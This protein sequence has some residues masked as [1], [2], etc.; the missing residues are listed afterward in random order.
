MSSE[1]VR[2]GLQRF[3]EMTDAKKRCP[4]PPHSREITM[5]FPLMTCWRCK[6]CGYHG[7]QMKASHHFPPEPPMA[8]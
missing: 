1:A 8:P 3:R 6:L 7:S 4:H 5:D 2:R